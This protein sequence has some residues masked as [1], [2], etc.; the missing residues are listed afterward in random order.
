MNIK[1]IAKQIIYTATDI[2]ILTICVILAIF[3]FSG[4]TVMAYEYTRMINPCIILI[5]VILSSYR[6]GGDLVEFTFGAIMYSTIRKNGALL[7]DEI[8]T[9]PE[10]QKSKVNSI[11]AIYGTNGPA[12]ILRKLCKIVAFLIVTVFLISA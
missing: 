10:P 5:L 11:V 12:M 1:R 3:T 6:F 7:D 4:N 2:I 8:R 9:L